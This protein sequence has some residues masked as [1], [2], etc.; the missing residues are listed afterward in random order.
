MR[1]L[2]L[3]I[4]DVRGI[5]SL[6]L[7][8]G[9]NNLVIWGPNGSGK[10]AVVDA[11]DF[12][13][14]GRIRRLTGRGTG[15]ITLRRHGP[16]VDSTPEQASVRALLAVPGVS[17]PVELRRCIAQPDALEC[18]PAVRDALRPLLHLAERG[19]HVL[20]RREILRFVTTEAG[21]RAQDIQHLL[22]L[23]PAET[24]RKALV[25][26]RHRSEESEETARAA[27]E[28]LRSR[29][30]AV[31]GLQ[32][33]DPAAVL[34]F[35]NEQ[36]ALLGASAVRE[37]RARDIRSGV[38]RPKDSLGTERTDARV[39]RSSLTTLRAVFDK[40]S[41]ERLADQD[42]RLRTRLAELR[43][44]HQLHR[45][46]RR[47]DL[48]QLGD[49]LIDES[50][51]CPLCETPWPV[52]ALHERLQA[53]LGEAD[54]AL[55]RSKEITSLAEVIASQAAVCATAA[56]S[57]AEAAPKLGE[58]RS[59]LDQ[60][61]ETGDRL[62]AALGKPTSAYPI[63]ELDVEQ[64]SVLGAPREAAGV[65]DALDRALGA[66]VP[67]ETPEHRA[68]DALIRLEEAL[69]P[70]EAADVALQRQAQVAR[71]ARSLS[72]AYDRARDAIL[73][74]LYEDV[75]DRFVAL[76]RQLHGSDETSFT[77]EL[78][79]EGAGLQFLVD[80]HGRGVHPPQ[81]LHSE[82][83]QDSM[84]ICLYLALAECLTGGVIDLTILDDV[85]M[86]VDA[87]H[88]RALCRLL[89]AAFPD[90]QLLITTHDRTW[91]GQ[92]RT[93]GVVTARHCVQFYGWQLTTGPRVVSE[94]D[95]WTRIDEDLSRDEVAGAAHRLRRGSEEYFAD[96]CEALWAPV[97]YRISGRVELGELLP[98]A[99]TQYRSILKKAKAAANAWGQKDAVEE[100]ALIESTAGQTFQR[101]RAE[102]WAVNE[103]VHY[104]AWTNFSRPDM[105]PVVEAFHDLFDVFRCLSCQRA[106]RMVATGPTPAGVQCGCGA[107][108]WNLLGP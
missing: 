15:G 69:V 106:L 103:N 78:T 95:L 5:R 77:A 29:V 63:D 16:H 73:G 6:T 53:R 43:S 25:T 7:Q 50:G 91:A 9:G 55:S 20:T 79:P 101:S 105:V 107:V 23:T 65:L 98:A 36:R 56:R 70:L 102:E 48:I 44:D 27:G 89:A 85:M 74:A 72:A 71:R 4:H 14:T 45:W 84:G 42:H 76:Y 31:A 26:V 39:V 57:L 1:L 3:D 75:R 18:D 62:A 47:R 93:E 61:A 92:L 8:P 22:N 2:A 87:E 81:A 66:L 41:V 68:W 104:N 37:L 12:L 32:A 38:I 97:R 11:I 88:R 13:L 21:T 40:T 54:S 28:G 67:T 94:G 30:A 83:H 82:G 52:G 58:N 19:Q 64:V 10:S 96:I 86:S 35:A 49:E 51:A 80:F 34:E 33:F 60:W 100:L 108:S 46:S 59:P 17:D 90:R 24:I 99:I